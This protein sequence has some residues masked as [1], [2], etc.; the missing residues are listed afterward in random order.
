VVRVLLEEEGGE[1]EV[2]REGGRIV[3]GRRE[4]GREEG[5]GEAMEAYLRGEMTE[6]EMALFGGG[7]REGGGEGGIPAFLKRRRV[8][9]EEGESVTARRGGSDGKGRGGDGLRAALASVARRVVSAPLSLLR[10]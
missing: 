9:S 5:K 7:G 10:K 6:A 1:E 3:K 2:E 4:G 8:K